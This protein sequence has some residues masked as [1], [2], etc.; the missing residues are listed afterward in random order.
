MNGGGKAA[1]PLLDLVGLGP[2]FGRSEDETPVLTNLPLPVP[3][4]EFV[5][6][7][8]RS[9]SGKSTVLNIV[10]GF[11]RPER[12]RCLLAGA[13]VTG[14]GP[15]RCVVFQEDALFPWLTVRENIGFGL[16]GPAWPRAVIGR[17]V[18]RFLALVG[19]GAYG[20]YLPRALSGG[21]KQR[22]ALARALMAQ[23]KLLLLDEPLSSLDKE[24]RLELQAELMDM[25]KLWN[26][27]FIL[28]THDPD[29]ART[30]GSQVLF[31]EKGRQV[32]REDSI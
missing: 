32:G 11:L 29:E 9:G 14:P 17:E 2:R 16:R 28:V 6:L 22:V 19:L 3:H 15:D 13:P 8:G 7:I 4:S 20:D 12:G 5:C 30:M 1:K 23:P 27:P 25:Q 10:A 24:T 26:I 18:D 21:M 31:L